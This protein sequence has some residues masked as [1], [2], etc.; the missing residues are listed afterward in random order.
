M[1]AMI[2]VAVLGPTPLMVAMRRTR[3]SGAP[4]LSRPV[5]LDLW[6]VTLT[7]WIFGAPFPTKIIVS[8][9]FEVMLNVNQIGPP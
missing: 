9:V 1:A 7:G 2:A 4:V 6:H 8:R 5:A 3:A